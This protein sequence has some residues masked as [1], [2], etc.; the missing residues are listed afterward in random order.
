MPRGISS[1]PHLNPAISYPSASHPHSNHQLSPFIFSSVSDIVSILYF[2]QQGALLHE[3]FP[4][5]LTKI[6]LN[7]NQSD[8]QEPAIGFGWV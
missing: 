5:L 8:N 6:L 1:C 7:C 2:D 3:I 4:S